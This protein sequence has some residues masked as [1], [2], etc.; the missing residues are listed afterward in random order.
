MRGYDRI[1]DIDR[2]SRTVRVQAGALVGD[3]KSAV[4]DL[5]LTWPPTHERHQ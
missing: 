2:R 3:V 4:R 5:G 1:L